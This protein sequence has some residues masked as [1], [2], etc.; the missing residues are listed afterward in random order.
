MWSLAVGPN[1]QVGIV[2]TQNAM[3]ET[4]RLDSRR[5]NDRRMGPPSRLAHDEALHAAPDF[6]SP[7]MPRN[8][9]PW[10]SRMR[11][12]RAFPTRSWW[13]RS[14]RFIKT[15]RFLRSLRHVELLC[16]NSGV[17]VIGCV[18]HARMRSRTSPVFE[19]QSVD[20]AEFSRIV[21]H[22]NDVQRRRMSPD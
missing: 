5:L 20:P 16:R 2:P 18:T 19:P 22:Q 8:P 21:G 13:R 4:M 6:W 9:S 15:L 10:L 7:G 12:R 3:F 1:Q 11:M 17:T 14:A